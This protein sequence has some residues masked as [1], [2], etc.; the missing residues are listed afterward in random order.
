MIIIPNETTNWTIPINQV[1][2]SITCMD[3][4][5]SMKGKHRLNGNFFSLDFR[6]K[7]NVN[8]NVIETM[9]MRNSTF[10]TNFEFLNNVFKG[11]I[12][13]ISLDNDNKT[14]KSGPKIEKSKII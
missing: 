6:N 11:K 8:V 2:I 1:I 13:N 14:S 10:D 5:G 12:T 3:L 7:V 9:L 4:V